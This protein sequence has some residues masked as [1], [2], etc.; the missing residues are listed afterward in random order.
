MC[1]LR[2]GAGARNWSLEISESL[3]VWKEEKRGGAWGGEVG[4]HERGE[5]FKP[6]CVFLFAS[7]KRHTQITTHFKHLYSVKMLSSH[8]YT[9]RN[10]HY[11]CLKE[12]RK[13]FSF[14][15][16]IFLNFCSQDFDIFKDKATYPEYLFKS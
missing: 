2:R 8:N 7:S 4:S 13:F 3:Y 5:G 12:K 1:G 15:F 10:N 9:K 6:Y 11:F 16:F 14:F